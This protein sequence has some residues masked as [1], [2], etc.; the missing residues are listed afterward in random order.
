MKDTDEMWGHMSL[1]GRGPNAI[2]KISQWGLEHDTM[3]WD[4]RLERWGEPEQ[5]K[6]RLRQWD[7]C[8]RNYIC[9]ENQRQP[10]Q[11]KAKPKTLVVIV[12]KKAKELGRAKN[13][14]DIEKD[15]KVRYST[16]GTQ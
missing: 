10:K 5:R 8:I 9:I 13:K 6:W 7:L 4:G 16:V 2:E 14:R 1:S 12:Q 11:G 15:Q 3:S